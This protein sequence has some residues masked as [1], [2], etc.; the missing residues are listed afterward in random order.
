MSKFVEFTSKG[1]IIKIFGRERA[2]DIIK[3]YFEYN[4]AV[5]KER[6]MTS[7]VKYNNIIYPRSAVYVS[8]HFGPFFNAPLLLLKNNIN[9]NFVASKLSTTKLDQFSKIIA[10]DD[11]TFTEDN[12][13]LGDTPSGMRR[14]IEEL[15]KGNS[16]F[17]LID[18]GVGVGDIK[19]NG[20]AL[21]YN[22]INAQLY[23]KSAIIQL[24]F[25]YDI[26][27]VPVFSTWKK[28]EEIVQINFEGTIYPADEIDYYST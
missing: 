5:V 14:I 27:I 1:S 23:V 25:K 22:L 19:K 4:N 28:E 11:L 15:K 7:P 18:T 21:T 12:V 8:F 17:S 13:L 16:L 20:R 26:P 6:F 3:G 10:A 24:A 2:V 9:L